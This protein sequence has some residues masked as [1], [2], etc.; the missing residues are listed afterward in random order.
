ML[1]EFLFAR[2]SYKFLVKINLILR[3]KYE[4][5]KDFRTSYSRSARNSNATALSLI[6]LRL[7]NATGNR[8]HCSARASSIWYVFPVLI[9]RLEMWHQIPFSELLEWVRVPLNRPFFHF[10]Y[11]WDETRLKLC[12]GELSWVC[13]R[14]RKDNCYG[15][16]DM[17]ILAEI[18]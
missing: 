1:Y 4:P 18:V 17:Q 12:P 13:F 6:L 8:Y 5:V 7:Y 3:I 2:K 10:L 11:T 9:N 16:R 15:L 14:D